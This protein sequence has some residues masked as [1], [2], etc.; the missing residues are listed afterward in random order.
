MSKV[1]PGPLTDLSACVGFCTSRPQQGVKY[2]LWYLKCFICEGGSLK[3]SHEIYIKD[4][5]VLAHLGFKSK[6]FARSLTDLS[7]WVGFC[8]SSPQQGVKY[9]LWYLNFFFV[10]GGLYTY[11]MKNILRT[12][13]FLPTWGLGKPTQSLKS[14][15]GSGNTFDINPKWTRT[16]PSLTY[17][18]WDIYR[19]PLSTI[20]FSNIKVDIWH[21]AVGLRCRNPPRH[22]SQLTAR[23]IPL[24]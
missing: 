13:K 23:A 14:V 12:A 18:S 20:F 7:V 9:Q 1:L 19:D 16:L 22:L 5:K 10:E 21:P 2:Q 3:I 11:P 17:C 24:T 8:T 4:G 15:K 6:V